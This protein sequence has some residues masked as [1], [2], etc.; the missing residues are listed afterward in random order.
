MSN[1]E[2]ASES[3]NQYI[4]VF[5]DAAEE[6]FYKLL[7]QLDNRFQAVTRNNFEQMLKYSVLGG[8]GQNYEESKAATL[9]IFS[10]SDIDRIKLLDTK[11]KSK[12]FKKLIDT[13]LYDLAF[14]S[15]PI[16]EFGKQRLSSISSAKTG[17][18]DALNP[19]R[20]TA[21][22]TRLTNVVRNI[23]YDPITQ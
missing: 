14:W 19:T 21:W 4:S 18:A 3:E 13:G 7:T 6:T 22:L 1:N 16:S 5:P 20:D 17:A 10:G 12:L 2:N 23:S 11:S 15:F 8:L 9:R